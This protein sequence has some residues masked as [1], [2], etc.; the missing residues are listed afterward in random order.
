MNGK[1]VQLDIPRWP[2]WLLLIG[3][4]ILISST[5]SRRPQ[6]P[7]CSFHGHCRSGGYG[8][9]WYLFAG[10]PATSAG[11]PAPTGPLDHSEVEVCSAYFG[12]EVP[13]PSLNDDRIHG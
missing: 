10:A 12:R 13:G 5:C 8:G 3:R 1:F 6:S 7:C 2:I 9:H 11:D 4:S